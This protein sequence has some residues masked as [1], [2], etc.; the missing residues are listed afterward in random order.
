LIY[1]INLEER[2]ESAEATIY[3]VK[4]PNPLMKVLAASDKW[5]ALWVFLSQP[6]LGGLE[7]GLTFFFGA[8]MGRWLPFAAWTLRDELP[9]CERRWNRARKGRDGNQQRC[10]CGAPHFVPYLLEQEDD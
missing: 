8:K 7:R 2:R 6:R 4:S 1:I 9:I 10:D 3:V 5:I